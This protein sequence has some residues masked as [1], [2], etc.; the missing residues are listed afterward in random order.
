VEET[1]TKAAANLMVDWV[2]FSI[3][4]GL[5][6]GIY[7][8]LTLS[9]NLEMGYAGIP[10]FGKVLFVA[11]GAA[12]AAN[13]T[14]RLAQ[15]IFSF[16]HYC[17]GDFLSYY[18]PG[19]IFTCAD[20]HLAVNPLAS[21]GLLVVGISLG[22]GVG[23]ALGYVASYPAIRLREDYLGMLL[24]AVAQFFQLVLAAYDPIINGTIGLLVIDPFR[25]AGSGAVR[26]AFGVG[27]ILLV[28]GGVYLYV[29]RTARSPLGRTLRAIR[30]NEDA[31]EAVGKDITAMRRKVL[32]VASAIS[33]VAGALYVLWW[34]AIAPD[35]WVRGPWTFVPW[36]MLI[37]GGAGNNVG[38]LVGVLAIATISTTIDLVGLLGGGI[39]IPIGLSG[40]A[41][42]YMA[43]DQNYIRLIAYGVA[44]VLIL[45]ARPG[46]IIIEKPTLTM[47]RSKLRGLLKLGKGETTNL[48]ESSGVRITATEDLD[49]SE[50]ASLSN[51]PEFSSNRSFQFLKGKIKEAVQK[52]LNPH[53]QS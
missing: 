46:G 42:Q 44:L 51:L 10:N 18:Q 41:I 52:L 29:E 13:V 20:T 43:V 8:I 5:S 27:V 7:A 31:A 53:M 36:V 14:G 33:G 23:A 32:V 35:T 39:Q 15:Y 25:W 9:L 45:Y 40:G 47:S 19:I 11:A 17:R 49:E 48:G 6:F 12:V 22:G 50:V 37:L 21:V 24:L 3:E 16:D 26:D 1:A 38:V 28:A 30:D 4:V 34:Q 2:S